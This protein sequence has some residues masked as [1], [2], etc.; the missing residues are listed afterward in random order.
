M[1]RKLRPNEPGLTLHIWAN[2][3][4]KAPLFR[5]DVDKAAGIRF[6]REEVALSKWT[7]LAYVL[8]T[9]HYHLLLRLNV[10]TLSHGMQRLN[11]RYA[12]HHNQR[13]N[14]RGHAFEQRFQCTVVTDG[15]DGELEV[16]RYLALNPTRAGMAESPQDYAWS[17]YGATV[18]LYPAD[19]IVDVGAALAPVSGSRRRYR[20]YVEEA[21]PRLRRK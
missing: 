21:D 9:T 11:R 14:L 19:P 12:L 1:P 17:S 6:L 8:M 13:H 7:C 18:G 5:D 15:L 20:A 2:G 3:V 10:A 16:A 4:R